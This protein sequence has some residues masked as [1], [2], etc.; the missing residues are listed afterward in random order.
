MGIMI[1]FLYQD[2]WEIYSNEY[3]SISHIVPEPPCCSGFFSLWTKTNQVAG[4]NYGA[5]NEQ[6]WKFPYGFDKQ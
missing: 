2:S 5:M 1:F 3:I 6:Q 4:T